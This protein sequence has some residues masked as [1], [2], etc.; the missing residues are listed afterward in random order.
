VPNP[1]TKGFPLLSGLGERF[2]AEH[3]SFYKRAINNLTAIEEK[4]YCKNN[5]RGF[6]FSETVLKHS[7]Q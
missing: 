6:S 1:G 2:P 5:F 7:K 3:P 4:A